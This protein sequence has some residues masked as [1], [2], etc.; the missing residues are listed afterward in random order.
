MYDYTKVKVV[1]S[2]EESHEFPV[3]HY[4]VG[5]CS[6]SYYCGLGCVEVV[7]ISSPSCL[8]SG[9]EKGIERRGEKAMSPLLLAFSFA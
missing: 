1:K 8:I 9:T 3:V 5:S 2:E 6:G 4:Y 7:R